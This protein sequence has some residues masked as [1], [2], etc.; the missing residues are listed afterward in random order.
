LITDDLYKLAIVNFGYQNFLIIPDHFAKVFWEWP[1]M[2]KMGMGYLVAFGQQFCT[3]TLDG[4]IGRTPS[5]N[6]I[7]PL[8]DRY[9]LCSGI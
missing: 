9:R 8:Q 5:I 3:G 2:T 7:F 1:D 6:S 4:S